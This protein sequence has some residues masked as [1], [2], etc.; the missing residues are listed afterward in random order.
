MIRSRYDLFLMSIGL[1]DWVFFPCEFMDVHGIRQVAFTFRNVPNFKHELKPP[2]D[3]CFL[4]G[5]KLR[6]L[7]DM[8]STCQDYR[9]AFLQERVI[10][11]VYRIHPYTPFSEILMG[12]GLFQTYNSAKLSMSTCLGR[13][14]RVVCVL[15]L[16]CPKLGWDS[17][18]VMW[19]LLKNV[20]QNLMAW[21]L[22]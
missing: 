22:K 11:R 6:D 18:C 14:I 13:S 3:Q 15:V 2:I 21:Y 20:P 5:Y 9:Y 10:L 7:T 16:R 17:L 4:V 8:F 1:L 12:E 19:G